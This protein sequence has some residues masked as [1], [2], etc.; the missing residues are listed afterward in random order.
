M[1]FSAYQILTLHPTEIGNYT[2]NHV[3]ISQ[4]KNNTRDKVSI[5]VET[6]NVQRAIFW[7][8][9]K[10]I[11]EEGRVAALSRTYA[12]KSLL[13]TMGR[14]KFAPK[15]PFPW[16]DPKTP[17]PASFLDPSDLWCQTASSDPPFFHNAL[18]RPTDARTYGPTDRPRENLTTT[19]R[20]ATTATWHKI[21][22]YV[23]YLRKVGAN[24]G[25]PPNSKLLER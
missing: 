10:V 6:C 5:T 8:L 13:V 4:T 11:W 24:S 18:D 12:V 2:D 7:G 25:I 15:Y 1:R 14:P 9:P 23:A 22:S 20:C 21:S 3:Y 16:T 19:G 17:L